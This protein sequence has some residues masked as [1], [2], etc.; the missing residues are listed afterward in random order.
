MKI[1]PTGPG[2]PPP[3]IS[4]DKQTV[5]KGFRAS[6]PETTAAPQSGQALKSITAEF[7]KTDLQDPA[8][9]DQMVSRCAGELAQNALQRGGGKVTPADT[10]N[11]T[12]ISKTIRSSVE[13]C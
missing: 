6:R 12:N 10:A 1:N 11:L 5:A 3:G 9:V 7:H 13:S 4:D 2:A 8:K